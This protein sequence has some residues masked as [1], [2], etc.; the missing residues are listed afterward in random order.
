[1]SKSKGSSFVGIVIGFK[2]W[3]GES[4]LKF[5]TRFEIRNVT[6]LGYVSNNCFRI[7]FDYFIIVLQSRRNRNK[8]KQ[9]FFSLGS[10]MR[11]CFAWIANIIIGI[12]RSFR[13][14]ENLIKTFFSVLTKNKCMVL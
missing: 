1:M 11:V 12:R 13:S 7:L 4:L 5:Y 10:Y 6:G 14:L 3:N 2:F 8:H 9:I